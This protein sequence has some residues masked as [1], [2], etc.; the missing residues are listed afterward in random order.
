MEKLLPE[1]RARYIDKIAAVKGMDPYEIGAKE[2][3]KSAD[4]LPPLTYPDLVNYL[5]FGV[6]AYTMQQFK[7]FKSLE[8]HQQFVNGWV[9]DLLTYTP[10]SCDN[11]IVSA[12][13]SQCSNFRLRLHEPL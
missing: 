3:G 9:H 8:A 1:A 4:L 7:A 6:S 10:P 13:V 12:K 5:V 11:T 2:W